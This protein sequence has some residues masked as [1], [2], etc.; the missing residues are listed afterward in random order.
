MNFSMQLRLSA[1]LLLLPAVLAL[2]LVNCSKD[3]PQAPETTVV[4]V[5]TIPPGA[6]DDL[7]VKQETSS[8]LSL[9]WS[10][11]GDDGDAGQAHHYDIRYSSSPIDDQNW[12]AAIPATGAPTPQ[13]AN[14][15]ESFTLAGLNSLRS[16]YVAIKSYDEED[17]ES[18]LSNCPMGTTKGES[19]PPAPVV[20]LEATTLNETE[21]LLTWTAPGDDGTQGTASRYDIRYRK[22]YLEFDWALA[23]TAIGEPS[24]KPGG[25]PDSFVVTGM[26]PGESYLFAMKTY[27]DVPN[28]SDISNLA[29]GMGHEVYLLVEPRTVGRDGEVDIYFKAS[30]SRVLINIL[31][32]EY[33]YPP[34]WVVWKHFEGYFTEGTH[35]EH[36]DLTSDQGEPTTYN[37]QYT[38]D[39]YWDDE[40]KASLGFRI[41]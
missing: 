25:E 2:P 17:N 33:Y 1:F 39:L 15:I 5:D 34:T 28:E 26:E 41:K 16:Y 38:I 12:D 30:A 19:L 35:I 22:Q 32:L 24:P 3:N 10:A 7:M 36:W 8:S 11:P 4:T 37:V 40:K 6:I 27:D 21:I 18:P 29:V 20:D 9:L 23:D 14:Y 13:A 31:R